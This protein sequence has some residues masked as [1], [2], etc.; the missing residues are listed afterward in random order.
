MDITLQRLVSYRVAEAATVHVTDRDRTV[1]EGFL[2]AP[3]DSPLSI[4]DHEYGWLIL[5][6]KLHLDPV[7]L[8]RLRDH[9]ASEAFLDLLVAASRQG[10]RWLDLDIDA[11]TYPDRPSY[12]W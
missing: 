2:K 9:G 7:R 3:A 12:T 4:R 10:A 5:V 6:H 11:A 1:L 8:E